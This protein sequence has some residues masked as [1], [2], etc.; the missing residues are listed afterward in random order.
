M[1][2]RRIVVL[3]NARAGTIAYRGGKTLQEVVATAFERPPFAVTVQLVSGAQL[4]DAAEL[5]LTSV[6]DGKCDAIV[7]GGGDGSIRTVASVLA[8]TGIP[9]GIIPLGTLNHFAKDLGLPSGIDE[10][11][12]IIMA[13]H[14]RDVDVGEVNGEIFINN[15]SIGIYPAL[16][17]ERERRQRKAGLPK[18]TAMALAAWRVLRNM[19]LRRLAICADD[20]VEPVRSPCVFVGNNVYYLSGPALGKRERLD[21][22]QLY[23]CF[24]KAQDPLSLFWLACRSILGRIDQDHALRV[25]SVPAVEIRSRASRL[26]VALDGEVRKIRSPLRYN[27]RPGALRVIVPPVAGR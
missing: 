14:T 9:L 24:T 18:W 19:P 21:G 8:G 13:G 6:R 16:V 1:H 5:A 11:V 25:H 17:F 10:L 26:L 20:W 22:G 27:S 15:S 7:V 23:L 3:L 4:H 12:K 2:G